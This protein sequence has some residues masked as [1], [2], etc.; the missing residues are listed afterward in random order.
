MRIS[1]GSWGTSKD[2]DLRVCRS[3]G[4]GF[5]R[6]G[7]RLEKRRLCGDGVGVIGMSIQ[8]LILLWQCRYGDRGVLIVGEY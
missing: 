5:V 4:D 2:D 3:I 6:E 1:P 8:L 7:G